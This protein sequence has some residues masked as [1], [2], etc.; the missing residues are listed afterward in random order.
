M[1][2]EGNDVPNGITATAGQM[3]S[4][5]SEKSLLESEKEAVGT[6]FGG[7][8][9]QDNTRQLNNISKNIDISSKVNPNSTK[10]RT[11][12]NKKISK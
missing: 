4:V 3:V 6:N 7:A 9:T 1:K 10:M 12:K 11:V 8:N 2:T 5:R